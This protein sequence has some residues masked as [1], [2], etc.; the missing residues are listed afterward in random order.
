M[1]QG[2]VVPEE[3]R[4]LWPDRYLTD[5]R[6]VIGPGPRP[7]PPRDTVLDRAT[8][9]VARLDWLAR[10]GRA[11]RRADRTERTL[12]CALAVVLT[13]GLA[14]LVPLAGVAV[15]RYREEQVLTPWEWVFEGDLALIESGHYS[16]QAE[17]DRSVRV[18]VGLKTL[19]HLSVALRLPDERTAEAAAELGLTE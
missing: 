2:A 5:G 12:A 7:L 19:A 10:C 6:L 15:V 8:A 4:P 14:L 18:T 17:F 3:A 1:R 13:G 9:A 11:W 16:R